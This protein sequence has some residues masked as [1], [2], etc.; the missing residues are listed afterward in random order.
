MVPKRPF[1]MFFHR[2]T[3]PPSNSILD[4]YLHLIIHLKHHHTTFNTW[5][6]ILSDEAVPEKL[7]A[8]YQMTSNIIICKTW[9]ETQFKIIHRASYPFQMDKPI[10][11]SRC[12]PDMASPI[13]LCSTAKSL[14]IML[15]STLS[16]PLRWHHFVSSDM[17]NPLLRPLQHQP[18]D[19]LNER[20]FACQWLLAGCSSK[21][22]FNPHRHISLVWKRIYSPY[23]TWKSLTQWFRTSNLLNIFL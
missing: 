9:Q 13:L 3:A 1:T 21:H 15:E 17:M 7:L 22:E 8:G 10:L 14:H 11:L 23:S 6:T 4:R 19:Y 18:W 20:I 5:A 2:S 12:V 16:V